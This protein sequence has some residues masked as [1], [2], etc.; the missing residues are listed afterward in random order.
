MSTSSQSGCLGLLLAPFLKKPSPIEGPLTDEEINKLR[1]EERLPYGKRDYF[2]S[3]AEI[4]FFHVLQTI[5]TDEHYLL[6]KVNLADLF[7][8]HR[9]MRIREPEEGLARSM[10]AL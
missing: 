6:S 9:P 3:A 2:L 1:E 4:S 8:V 5:L 10:W 7:F